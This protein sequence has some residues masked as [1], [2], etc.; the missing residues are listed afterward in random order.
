[1][2]DS[3]IINNYKINII[4]DKNLATQKRNGNHT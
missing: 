3:D 4:P 2:Y 1:M